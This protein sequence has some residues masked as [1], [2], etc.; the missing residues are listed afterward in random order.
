ML[1]F[2]HPWL[3]LALLLP[4]LVRRYSPAYNSARSGIV[5]PFFQAYVNHSGIDTSTTGVVLARQRWQ[6]I[7]LASVWLLFV[8]AL[9]KPMWL[10]QPIEIKKPAR[11]L[12]VAV[13]LSGSMAEQDFA[14]AGSQPQSRLAG[15]KQ[16]L[17]RFAEQ[18]QGDRLGL[19]VFG[20]APYLQLPFSEDG[21]LFVQLLE[22]SHVRMAGP[23]TMLGDAIG[24]AY[25][26]FLAEP[27]TEVN[28]KRVLLLL[29]DG[30]DSGSRVPPLEAAA[31]AASAG[32]KIYPVL[33]GQN[34][35]VAEQA[36]DEEQLIALANATGGRFFK[37]ANRSALAQISATLDKLEPSR[38][39]I[40]YFHPRREL[41][42]WPL[43]LALLLAQGSHL[44]FAY[45]GWCSK[46]GV[47]SV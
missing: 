24:Y 3:F 17:S 35:A 33:L 10:G 26:H 8:G 36:I 21:Q 4:L 44:W 42:Y 27:Q 9:A 20:D 41:Y 31:L 25:R 16:V 43:L 38:F 37:A 5:A 15:A 46:R 29:S 39:A 19:M 28:P 34:T 7:M 45:K 32:I 13:D 23:K 30:N 12:M 22:Q 40:S 1:V 6:K 14:P 2:E 11:D 18:R 47:A